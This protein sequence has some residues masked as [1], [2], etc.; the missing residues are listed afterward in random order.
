[1][2][3]RIPVPFYGDIA[4]TKKDSGY[5]RIKDSA[6][7]QHTAPI[8]SASENPTTEPARSQSSQQKDNLSKSLPAVPPKKK[9]STRDRLFDSLPSVPKFLRKDKKED[10]GKHTAIDQ[11]D[12]DRKEYKRRQS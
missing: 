3:A 11:N 8:V 6:E 5:T 2:K 7:G 1:M 4:I 10:L 12:D 9:L